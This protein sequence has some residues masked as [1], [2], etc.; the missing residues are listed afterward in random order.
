[1]DVAA[2]VLGG[3]QQHLR[4]QLVGEHVVDLAAE[5]DDPLPQQPLVD[6]VVQGG[7][8]HRSVPLR[9]WTGHRQPIA[10]SQE[11]REGMASFRYPRISCAVRERHWTIPRSGTV[12]S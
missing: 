8:A 5:E 4:G 1:V 2:R 9:W 3:E 11:W 10:G 6:R 12:V 7:S